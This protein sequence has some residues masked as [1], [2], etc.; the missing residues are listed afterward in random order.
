ML[1]YATNLALVFV[2][3]FLADHLRVQAA[4]GIRGGAKPNLWFVFLVIA[5][6]TLVAGLRFM[7]GTDYVNYSIA[8][9]D[10]RTDFGQAVQIH[11]TEYGYM[12]LAWIFG[13]FFKMP[14]AFL[15]FLALL[16]NMLVVL[17]LRESSEMFWFSCVLYILM[18]FYFTTFNLVRQSLAVSITFFAHKHLVEKKFFHYLLFVLLASLFHYSALILIPIYFVVHRPAWSR[19]I[20]FGFIAVG[21]V[22]VF[23]DSVMNV[24]FSL[25]SGTRYSVY[26]EVVTEAGDGV[27]ILRIAVAA[28]P[29]ALSLLFKGRLKEHN[30][31]VNMSAINLMITLLAT[32]Q[33]YFVRMSFYF[34]IYYLL[35]LP[36]LVGLLKDA[37]TKF[38]ACLALL[39]C[40]GAYCYVLLP[41]E[42]G[43]L[44]YQTIA[45]APKDWNIMNYIFTR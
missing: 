39:F 10:I 38:I 33:I 41:V 18:Y 3:A 12:A 8:Y 21:L 1:V 28:A 24:V 30:V 34:S 20:F 23:Y 17:S 27:G 26:E 29:V 14:F 40:Y 11:D 16:T 45:S 2:F 37:K 25:L 7:V 42:G 19:L 4:A 35:L 36:V 44:P 43:V 32:R 9:Q 31:I 13:C 15:A 6:L 22:L 5:S